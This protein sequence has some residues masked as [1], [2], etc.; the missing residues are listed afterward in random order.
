MQL[1]KLRHL[2]LF[3][4]IAILLAIWIGRAQLSE[5]VISSTMQGLGLHKVTTD[6][7]HLG[8]NQSHISHF[9]FTLATE[10]GLFKL[11]AHDISMSYSLEQLAQGRA[12]TLAINKLELNYQGSNKTS[13]APGSMREALEPLKIIAAL[14]HALREYVIFNTFSAEHI[15]LHGDSFGTLQDKPLRLSGANNDASIYAE[16]TLLDQPSFTQQDNLRQL[17][18]TRLSQDA[19]IAELRFSK[20]PDDAPAKLEF[21]IH[22]TDIQGNYD[23]HPE[24]LK[25]WLQPLA[26]VNNFIDIKNVSGTLTSSFESD[27]VIV[28]TITAI[29]DKYTVG[30]YYGDNI[31]VKLKL[32]NPTANPFQHI[33]MQNGSYIKAKR[34]S[35]ENISLGKTLINM[36]GELSSSAG[37][38]QFKGGVSTEKLALKYGS[39]LL[40]LGDIAA[41]I[42]SSPHKLEADGNFSTM[43]APAKFRFALVHDFYKAVGSLSIKPLKPLDLNTENKKLSLLLTP[44]PY[45]FDLLSGSIMLT[46]DATWSQGN[47]FSLTSKI[48]LDNAGGHYGDLVFSGL[49]FDHEFEILPKIH[50]TQTSKINLKQLD[51]GVTASNISTSLTLKTVDT[52][53]LPQLVIQDLRGEIFDGTFTADN[54][55]FDLNSSSNRFKIKATDIDLA[56]IVETQQLDD[57]VVT[58]RIDGTIPVEINDKGVFIQH[59]AFVN[60]IRAGSIRYNPAAGTDQLKQNP[61]T[62]ITLDA[63]KDFRYTHLSADVNFTPEGMLT[64][65]LQLKGTSPELDTKRPVH[66][67]INTEQNLLSLLKSLRYAEGVSESIDQ[68]VRRQ[69]EKNQK[70]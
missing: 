1:P 41:R 2:S 18:I 37:A 15:T 60:D 23:I 20:T 27:D 22:D 14:R 67:N 13:E 43:S 26:N 53:A 59:G 17:V 3:L 69:Y 44:W 35:Y 16:L 24:Q 8:L 9:G 30:K 19:L 66:L 48:N 10:T 28:S 38:L 25:H 33:K 46:A 40:Q 34:L 31:V 5:L 6:I 70:Q 29:T 61:I 63:L 39:Q 49:S 32:E 7:N 51:S 12:D 42:S 11:E 58:G 47:D 52:G 21:N 62:G 64:I 45:P 56:K 36:V 50:S 54:F 57:I 65:N 68:K 4:I 55:L